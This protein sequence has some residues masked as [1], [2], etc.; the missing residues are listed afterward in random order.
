MEEWRNVAGY[1]GRYQVSNLGN[2]RGYKHGAYTPKSV[3][4]YGRRLVVYFSEGKSSKR[5]AVEALVSNA[6][7]ELA[8]ADCFKNG[9]FRR[10]YG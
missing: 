1:N 3:Q 10:I 5:F 4:M 8:K 9:F 2:V 6:F 7:P